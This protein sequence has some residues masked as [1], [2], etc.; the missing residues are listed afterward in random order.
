MIKN[1]STV[2][3][4]KALLKLSDL[5]TQVSFLGDIKLAK[6]APANRECW[7]AKNFPEL[8]GLDLDI[9][10]VKAALDYVLNEEVLKI[11]NEE[12]RKKFI[13]TIN[14]L[15]LKLKPSKDEKNK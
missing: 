9:D 3:T 5:N 8:E 7:I 2:S 13:S 10:A 1:S 11:S 15:K 14:D 12:K 4:G 6:D